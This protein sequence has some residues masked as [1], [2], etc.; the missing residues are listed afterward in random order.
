MNWAIALELATSARGSVALRKGTGALSKD[1]P[2]ATTLGS[3]GVGTSRVRGCTS[4]CAGKNRCNDAGAARCWANNDWT[5]AHKH[6]S[7]RHMSCCGRRW[8]WMRETMHT[9]LCRTH[10]HTRTH[11]TGE[12][13]AGQKTADAGRWSTI[14]T[15][16]RVVSASFGLRAGE[17]AN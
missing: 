11:V 13:C 5:Q 7:K 14:S 4:Q 17:A 9:Q 16:L 10:P 12:R 6:Q 3:K 1:K 8:R 2:V 15:L